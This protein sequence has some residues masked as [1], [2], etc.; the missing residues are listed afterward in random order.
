MKSRHSKWRGQSS[1]RIRWAEL[2]GLGIIGVSM[3]TQMAFWDS[4]GAAVRP[5]AHHGRLG[6]KRSMHLLRPASRATG[7]TGFI[8]EIGNRL[9]IRGD[10]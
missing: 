8:R 1:L 9:R 4:R 10:R 3:T 5:S 2:W 7:I 6:S